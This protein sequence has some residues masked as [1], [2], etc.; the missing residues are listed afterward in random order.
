[1]AN[2]RPIRRAPFPRWKKGKRR[3]TRWNA[4]ISNFDAEDSR[5]E[6]VLVPS[7]PGASLPIATLI[8]GQID[9]EPWADD[10]EVTIDRIIGSITLRSD[11]LW[12]TTS[13]ATS[14]LMYVKMG[15][16]VNEEV[17]QD[18]AGTTIALFEQESLE[19]YEWLWLWGGY[20]ST[21]PTQRV[22]PNGVDVAYQATQRIEL[23]IK[24]RRKV[25]QSD[26]LNL[27]AQFLSDT[28]DNIGLVQ[29]I[30]DVR[31]ILMSR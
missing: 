2:Q 19:D 21:D 3:P 14:P 30:T 16:I 13:S 12:Q 26:E 4:S 27:Y 20:I 24:N 8:S 11:T 10:Q 23:D 15:L 31:A 6:P 9:V 7:G 17:T 28:A 1:M 22:F 29:C 25:G 18:S 5:I